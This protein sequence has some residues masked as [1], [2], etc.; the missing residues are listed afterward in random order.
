MGLNVR[1]DCGTPLGVARR[2]EVTS[3]GGK[4][5]PQKARALIDQ[6]RMYVQKVSAGGGCQRLAFRI[7]SPLEP[8]HVAVRSPTIWVFRSRS[9]SPSPSARPESY[10]W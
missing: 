4:L 5:I 3:V 8:T 6:S 2:A 1:Q 7:A 10:Q 9:H